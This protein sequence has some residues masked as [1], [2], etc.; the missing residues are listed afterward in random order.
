LDEIFNSAADGVEHAKSL[1]GGMKA[2][3]D[4]LVGAIEEQRPIV[5]V[6]G[7]D[8]WTESENSNFAMF[9]AMRRVLSYSKAFAWL[10]ASFPFG[11]R[12]RVGASRQQAQLTGR[13]PD[14]AP[15]VTEQRWLRQ[16]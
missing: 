9:G 12:Y 7:Q 14:T 15:P 16:L 11:R 2:A 8:A 1:R 10:V 6:L 3:R 13:A 4:I 5:L